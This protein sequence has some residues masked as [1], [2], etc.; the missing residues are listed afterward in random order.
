MMFVVGECDKYSPAG[1]KLCTN[2]TIVNWV[3]CDDCTPWVHLRCCVPLVEVGVVDTFVC[4]CCASKEELFELRKPHAV[5]TICII[6][7][8]VND[9]LR[10]SPV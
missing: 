9:Y 2:L 6:C 10:S 4:P 5:N 7:Y 8:L 1:L 3:Q